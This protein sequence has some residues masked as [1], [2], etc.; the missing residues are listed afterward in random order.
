MH[1]M[2]DCSDMELDDLLAYAQQ[3]SP[4]RLRAIKM[5]RAFFARPVT[6]SDSAL[7]RL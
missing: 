3:H 6:S 1:V 4:V 7:W 2:A 5:P